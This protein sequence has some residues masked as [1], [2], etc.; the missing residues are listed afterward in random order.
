MTYQLN[1]IKQTRHNF[2][3]LIEPL[4]IDELNKIP[5]GFNNNIAWNLGHI[6]ASQQI[7][8]Y[9]L[10][11]VLPKIGQEFIDKYKKGTKPE[12]FIGND[13]IQQ[14][15]VLSLT[16]MDELE[17]D[18][19]TKLFDNFKTYT[20][21]YGFELNNINDAINFFS[22]HDAMHFGVSLS[23]KKLI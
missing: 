14:L 1:L 5:D 10:S 20:T 16:L 9:V 3:N 8:C 19:N 15:K 17:K 7:L 2:L 18:M 12:S 22:V 13:E 4:S 11:G 23:I 6:V 21:S